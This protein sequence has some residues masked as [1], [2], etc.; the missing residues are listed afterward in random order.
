MH[1]DASPAHWEQNGLNEMQIIRNEASYRIKRWERVW[2]Y[3]LRSHYSVSTCLAATKNNILCICVVCIAHRK[4]DSSSLLMTS[5]VSR[6]ILFIWGNVFWSHLAWWH[7]VPSASIAIA[8]FVDYGV[9]QCRMQ[10]NPRRYARYQAPKV[11][12]M[13]D[14]GWW[15][16]RSKKPPAIIGRHVMLTI[17][18]P[19]TTIL[20]ALYALSKIIVR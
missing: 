1:F 7:Q 9:I 2:S 6:S 10:C 16:F 12:C 19:E 5:W 20:A 13:G 17:F 4:S 15:K 8:P 11:M 18:M 3:S 14:A